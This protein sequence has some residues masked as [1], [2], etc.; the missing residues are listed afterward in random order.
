MLAMAKKPRST[1]IAIPAR[2]SLKDRSK[3][4]EI[5]NYA[6]VA[7]TSRNDVDRRKMQEIIELLW[8]PGT[9]PREDGDAR[10][11]R[12]MDLFESINPTEGIE[13]MLALQ[14]VGAHHAAM[15]CLRR[16]MIEKQSVEARNQNLG[17]AQKLMTLYANQLAALDKHR[18]KGQQQVTVRHVNVEAGGQ[19][20]LGNVNAAASAIDD[21]AT[22]SQPIAAQAAL[23]A[24]VEAILP[25]AISVVQRV[26]VPRS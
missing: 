9:L 10:I 22:R 13:A 4:H 25:P 19:A 15:E 5:L 7:Q 12:A 8:L 1:E 20:I 17:H 2:E 26:R 21:A 3:S 18:G 11:V 16:A 6:G 14:M 23:P 24:P